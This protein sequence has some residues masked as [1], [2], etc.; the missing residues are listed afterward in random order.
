MWNPELKQNFAGAELNHYGLLHLF[1]VDSWSG[2]VIIFSDDL[3]ERIQLK[4]TIAIQAEKGERNEKESRRTG[5]EYSS[6]NNIA[7]K[8]MKRMTK[9]FAMNLRPLMEIF[10]SESSKQWY[11]VREETVWLWESAV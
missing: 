5:E 1:P 2:N 10:I 6:K 9:H 4:A 8:K 11:E 3:A 7:V